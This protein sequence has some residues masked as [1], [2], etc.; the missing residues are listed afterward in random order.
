MLL[1]DGDSASASEIVAGAVRD[2]HR[3]TIVGRKTYGKWSVQS[4]LPGPGQT[5]MPLTISVKFYSPSGQTHGKVGVY[6]DVAVTETEPSHRTGYRGAKTD[7]EADRDVK[8]G[9][10]LLRKQLARR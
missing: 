7:Y 3:G 6:P 10:D 9:L 2:H 4:I 1:V 5:G 8:T